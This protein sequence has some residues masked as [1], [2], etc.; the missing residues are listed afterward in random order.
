MWGSEF[1]SKDA[2]FS[3]DPAEAAPILNA[4]LWTSVRECLVEVVAR[5]R[6]FPIFFLNLLILREQS[7]IYVL[8]TFLGNFDPAA[9]VNTAKLRPQASVLALRAADANQL[10]KPASTGRRHRS[11]HHGSVHATHNER[12]RGQRRVHHDQVHSWRL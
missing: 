4:K 8:R 9:L 11:W 12:R 1:I 5:Y 3:G 10:L 6:F 7:R 2:S